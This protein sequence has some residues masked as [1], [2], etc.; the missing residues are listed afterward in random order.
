MRLLTL[1]VLGVVLS[2]ARSAG[3]TITPGRQTFISYCI[4]SFSAPGACTLVASS[5]GSPIAASGTVTT[6]GETV[7]Y[8]ASSIAQEFSLGGT[9][10]VSSTTFNSAGPGVMVDAV[11]QLV[12]LVTVSWDP[13]NGSTGYLQV[14]YTLDG[15][16]SASGANASATFGNHG[17]PYA[18]VKLGV[19]TPLFPFGCEA[20]DSPSVDGLFGG[21]FFPI[22]YGQAVPLWFQLE[23]IA[24]TGFGPGRPTGAGTSVANFFNTAT[25]G[26]FLFYDQNLVPLVGNPVITSALN[27]PYSVPEP[28]SLLLLAIG[29]AASQRQRIASRIVRIARRET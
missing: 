1:V 22:V 26:G 7:T 5:D 18:C 24:G 28:S 21:A 29:V 16:N 3:D 15:F 13:W 6:S 27:L 8:A 23:S 25:I 17:V 4:G 9:A 10:L 11:E 2:A 19:G 14:F 12:D 20:H